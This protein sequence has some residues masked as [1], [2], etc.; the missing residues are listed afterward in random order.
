MNDIVNRDEFAELY[1]KYS[2]MKGSYLKNETAEG[3]LY[4]KVD[5]IDV[6]ENG[7][8]AELSLTGLT[9]VA[10]SDGVMTL[11]PRSTVVAARKTVYSALYM[12]STD[13]LESAV[14]VDR[15]EFVDAVDK[16]VVALKAL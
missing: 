15:K 14:A 6:S 11:N 1:S 4:M 7:F 9:L 8:T 5:V 12:S 3:V 2:G 10:G 13:E 16:F